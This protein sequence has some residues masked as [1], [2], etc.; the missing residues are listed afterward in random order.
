[1]E[2]RTSF[3]RAAEAAVDD[4][5]GGRSHRRRQLHES[6]DRRPGRRRRKGDR[7]ESISISDCPELRPE[8]EGRPAAAASQRVCVR[9][10]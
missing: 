5:H 1:M 8:H 7:R 6:A 4:E 9:R 10:W 3:V 2:K